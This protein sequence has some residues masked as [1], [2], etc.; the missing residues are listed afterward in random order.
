[1]LS[2][3]PQDIAIGILIAHASTVT[4]ADVGIPPTIL[5]MTTDPA[6]RNLFLNSH[7][8]KDMKMETLKL[9][10]L[11]NHQESLT[12]MFFTPKKQLS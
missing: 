1:M 9:I 2:H 10:S 7:F 12:I 11:V 8:N 6:T 4:N 5:K 3:P